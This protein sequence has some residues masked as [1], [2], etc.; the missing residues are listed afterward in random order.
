M[1]S[2]YAWSIEPCRFKCVPHPD[3]MGDQD[4]R[5]EMSRCPECQSHLIELHEKDTGKVLAYECTV[6]GFEDMLEDCEGSCKG[7]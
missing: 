1:E 3:Y 4:G 2:L 7:L 5:W 6:C